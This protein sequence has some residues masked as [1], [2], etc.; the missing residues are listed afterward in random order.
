MIRVNNTE[1]FALID[2]SNVSS[3]DLFKHESITLGH[4]VLNPADNQSYTIID[5]FGSLPGTSTIQKAF[6]RDGV[7]VGVTITSSVSS[8]LGSNESVTVSLSN[9]TSAIDTIL[10]SS[11]RCDARSNVYDVT[12]LNI[13]FNADDRY[14]VII[15]TPAWITQNPQGVTW[16]V[17]LHI[18]Y[19]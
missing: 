14:N 2:L 10:S 9:R 12:G 15:D 19:N 6:K 8:T 3:L 11:V 4:L 16:S 17:V 5:R 7:V 18:R 1:A 13:A